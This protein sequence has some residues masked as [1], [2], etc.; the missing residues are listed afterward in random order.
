[1]N[2]TSVSTSNNSSIA[3]HRRNPL[4]D[5]LGNISIAWKMALMVFVLFLSTLGI[6]ISAYIGI[7]NLRYQISNIYDF[8]LVPIVAIQKADVALTDAEV[9]IL[10]SYNQNISAD[11]RAQNVT[12]IAL[13]NQVAQD[14]IA[15]YDKEWVTTT[16]PEFTQAL[17]NGG[18][19]SLQQQETTA[20][21]NYHQ[22]FD[23]Y[24][25]SLEQ[26]L[27][28]VNAG[29][30]D[31]NMAN[32]ALN[33][34]GVAGDHLQ[35]LIDINNQFADFSNSMAQATY[36]QVLFSSGIV[37]VIGIIL[38]IL[39][40]Y[41]IVVSITTRLSALTRSAAAMQ[42]GNL[43]QVVG[44][45]GRDEV[46]LLGTAFNSMASQLKNLFGTLEQ[47]VVEA[48]HS[49]EL[50]AEVGRSVSQ[51]RA[52]D[53]ML[54]DAA[55]LIRSR[56]DL[57]YAQVYLV[58]ANQTNL[59]LQ[60]GTGSVGAELV[61]R[62]H[63]L[64]L[65]SG[66]INGRAAT[67]KRSVVV[68]DTAASSTFRANPLLPDTRS[69]MA[70]PLLVGEKAVGVLDL[71]SQLA[72]A[73]NPDT[74]SAFEA[75]A[76]QL[77]I[78]IQNANLL[79]EAEQAR[80]DVEK[81]AARQSH[82]NWNDYL[83]AIHRPEHIGY[84]YD[85]NKVVPIAEVDSLPLAVD[86]N[87]LTA[88]IS[89]TGESLGTLTVQLG[90]GKR[91]EQA[92]ELVNTVARQVA[93]QV[94][95]LRLL[96]SA[97][98]YRFK[99]EQASRRLTHEGWKSYLDTKTSE[100]LS[101]FYDLKDVK[102]YDQKNKNEAECPAFTLPLKV[103]DET[104]GNFSI[105]EFDSDNEASIEFVKSVAERLG[106]HI[107]GLRLS[108]QIEKRAYE[109]A[110]IASVS[111]TAS[112]T[113]DPAKLLQSVVD[114]TKDSFGFYHAH[115]YLLNEV[116]NSL[117]L[118]AGAGDVG[119]QMVAEGHSIPLDT[120]RSLV[121]RSARSRV[122]FFVNDTRSEPDF[123]PNPLLP[124]TRSE[125]AVPMLVGDKVIGVFD[126]QANTTDRF[127]EDDIRIQTTLA[128]QIS[129]AVQ[130][131]RT[132]AQAQRQAEREATLNVISQKIQGA[133]TVEAALQIAAREL[134]H[135]LGAP[136]TIAQLGIKDRNNGGRN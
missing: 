122:G 85:Q 106:T 71:Q 28:S 98:R 22:S 29:K 126:V 125:L 16:S 18:K 113:L 74:L 84:I 32:K 95:S 97:E 34:L 128:S 83:D 118:T 55:E 117:E 19:L 42:E 1:M 116:G 5:F 7:Q 73:L 104:V 37:L 129:V 119:K 124:N 111:T 36:R 109:L 102:P 131:A 39:L 9:E 10:Q 30:P 110:T 114:L 87:T 50:A 66:S 105:Q 45:A 133:T 61:S 136:L 72:N 92:F 27:V 21:A 89:V 57:Y 49:L 3:K 67:E 91:N 77:A 43:D 59:I 26:Y 20:L 68:S 54:K 75:L 6:T 80:T 41:L 52:L 31:V 79:A 90:E 108:E 33:D 115:I 64:P 65:N 46:S 14:V 23:A 62:H 70:V 63:S 93:Q 78:A 13:N 135:A 130:N 15:R 82:T 12:K 2:M 120:E 81:Q 24:Q 58:D 40:S 53:I 60:S 96:D 48:T 56:F 127:A 88:P 86:N 8:M 69:E 103:R 123:L 17:R 94:E 76:G 112:S 25:K 132:F 101:Y 121:A 99:A 38:G 107:E 47:R 44:V 11:E 51:V 100:S 4:S 35:T 134:G